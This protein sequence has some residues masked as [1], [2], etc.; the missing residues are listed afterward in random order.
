MRPSLFLLPALA[1]F[2]LALPP[3]FAAQEPDEKS[4]EVDATKFRPLKEILAYARRLVPGKVLDVELE[5]D[6]DLD[7]D[8]TETLWVYEIE[9][10]TADN[11]V[12]ELEFDAVTGRLVEIEGAPWP[13]G[14]PRVR[15]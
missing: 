3:A 4:I 5:L 2:L 13:A 8:Q 12:V 14:V 10:L 6:V 9:V 7:D 1:V 15:P 11:R